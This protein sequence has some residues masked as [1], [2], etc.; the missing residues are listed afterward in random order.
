[1]N[2]D[3]R[4]TCIGKTHKGLAC[5]ATKEAWMHMVNSPELK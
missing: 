5:P 1:M 4:F 3:M 2:K